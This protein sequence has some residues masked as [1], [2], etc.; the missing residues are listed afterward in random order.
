MTGAWLANQ[1]VFCDLTLSRPINYILTR[2]ET[3]SDVSDST[4]TREACD[5][6]TRFVSRR[7]QQTED[8][9]KQRRKT[10]N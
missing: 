8:Y 6:T 5:S 10:N 7:L 9:N 1:C 2:I 3:F 4:Q